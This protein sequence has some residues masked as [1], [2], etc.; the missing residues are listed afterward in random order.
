[1]STAA[2]GSSPSALRAVTKSLSEGSASRLGARGG[3]LY[4]GD[5]ARTG[6]G[7]MQHTVQ[8]T[9]AVLILC[10]AR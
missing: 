8:G 9:R 7:V 6:G 4:S 2:F 10:N 3:A 1:M 5:T